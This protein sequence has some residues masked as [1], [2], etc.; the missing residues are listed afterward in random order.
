[1]WHEQWG[2]LHWAGAGP[3]LEVHGPWGSPHSSFQAVGWA[4]S[5]TVGSQTLHLPKQPHSI[6]FPH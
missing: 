5:L 3:E 4:S 1:M 6:H 2:S